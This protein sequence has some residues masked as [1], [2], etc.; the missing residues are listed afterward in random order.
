MKLYGTKIFEWGEVQDI[1]MT[2]RKEVII[3][4]AMHFIKKIQ[5]TPVGGVSGAKVSGIDSNLTSA[6]PVML[7]MSDTLKSPDRGYELLFDEVDMRSSANNTF[8]MLDVS[9][10]ATFYQ[11]NEGTEAKLSK[12]PTSSKTNVAMLRYTGGYN[13][14][15][16][17]LRFNQYYKIDEL[18]ADTIRRWFDNKATIF[19]GLMAALSSGI[20]ET[21]STDDITTI[22]NACAQILTDLQAAGYPVDENSEFVITCNP[23]LR[24]RIFKAVAG[25]FINPN[26]NNSQIVYNIRTI[27]STT[28]LANTSYYVS[29][30][31][32]KNKRGEWEDLNLRPPQRNELVLGAAHVWT[33]A[34]NGIIGES[35]QHRRCAL[36]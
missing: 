7:V 9:G 30:P 11:H 2:E 6:V 28:K 33:G 14:L 31:G 25:S 4:A 23:K 36:S 24:G 5:D 21:F 19:Y 8:D 34:Y 32:G 18:T 15:D 20:N 35:K 16:D 10:G 17:W 27:I 29:L 22:N 1:P 13:I 3:E 26:A 12:I